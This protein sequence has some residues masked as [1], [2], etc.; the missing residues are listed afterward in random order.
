MTADD[1]VRARGKERNSQHLKDV[2]KLVVRGLFDK[3]QLGRGWLNWLAY[4][5]RQGQNL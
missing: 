2:S 3:S 1:Q 4:D 5:P